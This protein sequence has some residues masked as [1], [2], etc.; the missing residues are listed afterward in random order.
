MSQQSHL[1]NRFRNASTEAWVRSLIPECPDVS[2]STI[3]S[4]DELLAV[5][6]S[7]CVILLD[8]LLLKIVGGNPEAALKLGKK[9]SDLD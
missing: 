3:L 9:L 8:T 7:G 1:Q 2:V 6:R 4:Q 5:G